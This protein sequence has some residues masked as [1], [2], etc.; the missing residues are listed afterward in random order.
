MVADTKEHWLSETH[1]SSGPK[2]PFNAHLLIIHSIHHYSATGPEPKVCVPV[3]PQYIWK[4]K[5]LFSQNQCMCIQVY[6]A[7]ICFMFGTKQPFVTCS[8]SQFW[9]SAAVPVFM[10]VFQDHGQI[11]I[12]ICAVC[13]RSKD[14][15][16][17]YFSF[18]QLQLF[19]FWI[20]LKYLCM[21]QIILILFWVLGAAPQFI[22]SLW[23]TFVNGK[24]QLCISWLYYILYALYVRIKVDLIETI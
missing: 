2:L 4:N 5:Q 1:S 13:A 16:S 8:F 15:S 22:L 10:C 3:S 18:S 17:F 23:Q 7:A 24:P 20:A 21:F 19:S 12:R 9:F 11:H 14:H 6:K